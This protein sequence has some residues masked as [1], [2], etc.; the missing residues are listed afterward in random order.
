MSAASSPLR[1]K[2]GMRRREIL[3]RTQKIHTKA[4]GEIFSETTWFLN[5]SIWSV[6]LDSREI[7]GEVQQTMPVGSGGSWLLLS[8]ADSA[9][10]FMQF[11]P[12]CCPLFV[13]P[14]VGG[15]RPESSG[16]LAVR[17]VPASPPLRRPRSLPCVL[18]VLR[19]GFQCSHPCTSGGHRLTWGLL[20]M[21]HLDAGGFKAT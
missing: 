9:S 7:S 13:I 4:S 18:V 21:E 16:C 1:I 17:G 20:Y 12:A 11:L 10:Q 2:L 19:C 15:S 5:R 14:S 3:A 8:S 6:W